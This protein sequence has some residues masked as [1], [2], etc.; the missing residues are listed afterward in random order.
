MLV[1]SRMV[2]LTSYCIHIFIHRP[3]TFC[4]PFHSLPAALPIPW[5]CPASCPP[6]LA[7]L[8]CRSP[9]PTRN[10]DLRAPSTPAAPLSSARHQL[11]NFLLHPARF[12]K[13]RVARAHPWAT[14]PP[15]SPPFVLH[16]ILA[17]IAFFQFG[18]PSFSISRPSPLFSLPATVH[19][20]PSNGA[21]S[22]S[23][24]PS[25]GPS[26]VTSVPRHRTN[27]R[28][29]HPVFAFNFWSFSRSGASPPFR[30]IQIFLPRP[31]F[32]FEPSTSTIDIFTIPFTPDILFSSF[33][34][35]SC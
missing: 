12:Y 29:P 21:P 3:L 27:P 20:F 19:Y 15:L 28:A 14:W 10:P 31:F 8:P 25:S 35:G 32:P 26:A 23:G 13:T 16:P 7:A 24:F 17:V 9:C 11:A 1:A 6:P 30:P 2:P 22:F 33:N 34:G 5:P 18:N 4:L